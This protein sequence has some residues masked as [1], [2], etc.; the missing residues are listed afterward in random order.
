M[1]CIYIEKSG[2]RKMDKAT[3]RAVGGAMTRYAIDY[4][5]CM[6][7][8]LCTEACPTECIKMG[9]VHDFSGYDRKSMIVEFTDLARQGHRTVQPYWMQNRKMADWVTQLKKE[10][11]DR[12]EP[13]REH[14]KQALVQTEVSVKKSA[15]DSP[16]TEG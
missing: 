1:D 8:G 9:N 4:S 11:Q 2:V 12:A 6:F 3:G 10:W 16:K 14:M 15:D 13:A 5:K 7:C